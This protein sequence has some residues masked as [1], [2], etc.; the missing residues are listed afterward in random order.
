M[1]SASSVALGVISP[2]CAQPSNWWSIKRSL[3]K[4]HKLSKQRSP[5]LKSSSTIT[6]T[7]WW[8]RRKQEG[9]EEQGIQCKSTMPRWWARIK[10]R[11]KLMLK[12]CTLSARM[13]DTLPRSVLPSLSR[14][15]KQ[16]SRGKAMRSNIWARKKRLNPNKSCY[17]CRERGHMAHSCPRGNNSKPISIDDIAMLR[18]DGNGTSMVA[19]AKHPAT[20]TK[21]SLSML[22]LTWED[23][24]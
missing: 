1:S 3:N 8:W 14:R 20:Q 13:M 16:L 6:V 9:V 21:A 7:W 19:I 15:L 17:L 4:S 12:S 5:K 11:R 22:L 23:P 10:T 18:K 2:Q 24:N